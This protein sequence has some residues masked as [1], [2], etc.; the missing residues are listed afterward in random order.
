MGEAKG[1]LNLSGAEGEAQSELGGGYA[2]DTV[3]ERER[4]CPEEVG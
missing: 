3:E 4:L 1:S 2:S